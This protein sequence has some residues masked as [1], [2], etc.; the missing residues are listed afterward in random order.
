MNGNEHPKKPKNDFE[1]KSKHVSDLKRWNGKALC[2][3]CCGETEVKCA[4]MFSLVTLT[5][6]HSFIV[7]R[8]V[9]SRSKG[10]ETLEGW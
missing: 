8:S 7:L 6:L 3:V 10:R 9:L 4:Y 5:I 2:F 1:D